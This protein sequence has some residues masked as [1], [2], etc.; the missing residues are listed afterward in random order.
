MNQMVENHHFRCNRS[1]VIQKNIND[2]LLDS[3]DVFASRKMILP[4]FDSS[5]LGDSKELLIISLQLLDAKK[6]IPFS[7]SAMTSQS[8]S[9]SSTSVSTLQ[10][11]T[12]NLAKCTQM[13]SEPVMNQDNILIPPALQDTSST[14]SPPSVDTNASPSALDSANMRDILSPLVHAINT[15]T[16]PLLSTSP[17]DASPDAE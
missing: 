10:S 16:A 12:N 6:L 1:Q 4:P 9:S 5:R 13:S 14:S 3:C 17:A 7:L 8:S 2:K 11:L 15:T